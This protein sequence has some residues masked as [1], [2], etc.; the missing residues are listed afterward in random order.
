MAR[1]D[2]MHQN[3]TE[4]VRECYEHAHEC[5]HQAKT[6]RDEDLRADFLH[7]EQGWLKLARSYELRQ[8]FTVLTNEAAD[9]PSLGK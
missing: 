3:L 7:L 2:P 1:N 5:A 4:E 8:R 6:I 9:A